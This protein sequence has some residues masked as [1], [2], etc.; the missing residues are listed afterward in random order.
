M[1]WIWLGAFIF[2]A[3]VELMTFGLTSIWFAIGSL[4]A[5]VTYLLGGGWIAQIVTFIVVTILVLVLLRPYAVK[6]INN[7]AEKTNVEA[8]VGKTAKVVKT[9][10]NIA[11]T[12]MVLIDG[13]EWT[14]RS[15]NDTVIEEGELVT[16]VAVEGVKV[17]VEK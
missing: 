1:E 16:I 6:Y 12:G 5:C 7:K 9:V 10:D 3:A 4:A 2:F 14:A 11:A 8:L 15:T 13:I 17:I